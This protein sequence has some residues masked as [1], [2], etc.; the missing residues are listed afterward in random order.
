MPQ[1]FVETSHMLNHPRYFRADS[2]NELFDKVQAHADTKHHNPVGELCYEIDIDP[3]SKLYSPELV[4]RFYFTG[5]DGKTRR[6][7][8]L[9]GKLDA[10]SEAGSKRVA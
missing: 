6:F 10:S 3:A 8:R 7:M 5:R 9:K 2:I 1:F 4:V